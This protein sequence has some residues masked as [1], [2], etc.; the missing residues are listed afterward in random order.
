[1]ANTMTAGLSAE[2]ADFYRRF[3]SFWADPS[4]ER[5][6]EIIGPDAVIHFS[7]Q[8]TF[9]GEEYKAVMQGLLDQM[10]GLEVTPL[11]CAGN[12]DQ[13][14]IHWRTSVPIDGKRVEYVGFDRF[15]VRDGMAV[16]EYV[17]FDTAVL[18]AADAG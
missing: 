18:A 6:A 5:V 17:I 2:H 3:Q 11:D 12:G 1:M 10:E 7:G 4:G 9:T 15:T 14:Y 8:G 13:L 16:E